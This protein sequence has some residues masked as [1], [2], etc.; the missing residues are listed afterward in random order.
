MPAIKKREYWKQARASCERS[1]ALW[2]Q[3]Q[4]LGEL[5]SGENG[6]AQKV[7]ECI[8]QCDSRFEPRIHHSLPGVTDSPGHK[9]H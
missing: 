8:A 4:K 7:A 6:E 1:L 2:N 9:L 3:K 5:E